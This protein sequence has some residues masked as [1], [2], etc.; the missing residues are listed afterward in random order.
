MCSDYN[1][2]H[3]AVTWDSTDGHWAMY[4]DR[5][6]R[7]SGD[8]VKTGSFIRGSGSLVLGQDQDK[9]GGSFDQTQSFIGDLSQVRL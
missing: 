4:V 9:F 5:S 7:R 6:L 8:G 3:V 2:H 1:W